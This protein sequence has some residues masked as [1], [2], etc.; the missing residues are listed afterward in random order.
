MPK[1]NA[2]GGRFVLWDFDGT[3]AER[4][5]RW[6]GALRDVLDANC[7]GHGLTQAVIAAELRN[8]F[9]WHEPHTAHPHLRTPELWWASLRSVIRGQLCDPQVSMLRSL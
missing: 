4:P 6:S 8:G 5:G 1:T 2:A 3:L 7:P 9:P